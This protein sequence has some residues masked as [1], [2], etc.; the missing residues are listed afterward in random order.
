MLDISKLLDFFNAAKSGNLDTLR[1]ATRFISDINIPS[2]FSRCHKGMTALHIIIHRVLDLIER[3]E[4]T[5]NCFEMIDFLIQ[6]RADINAIGVFHLP[7]EHGNNQTRPERVT[8]LFYA[9]IAYEGTP[10]SERFNF[11]R[12][13]IAKGADITFKILNIPTIGYAYLSAN[14]ELIQMMLNSVSPEK[15]SGVIQDCEDVRV[16]NL[17]Q[18]IYSHNYENPRFFSNPYSDMK[19]GLKNGKIKN[20]KDVKD[21]I[22]DN[23]GTRSDRV[24][25]S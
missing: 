10:T 7:I 13:L 24:L 12:Y 6:N 4:D 22:Y 18:E 9:L 25:K 3:N 1:D 21:Y 8:A 11:V 5:A 19:Q 16:F 15:L 14:Q 17:F 2:N 23:P 20:L